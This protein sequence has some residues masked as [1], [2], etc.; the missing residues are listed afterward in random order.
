MS[1]ASVLQKLQLNWGHAGL[2]LNSVA[3]SQQ[4]LLLLRSLHLQSLRLPFLVELPFEQ[5]PNGKYEPR[6]VRGATQY[7]ETCGGEIEYAAYEMFCSTKTFSLR[8]FASAIDALQLAILMELYET[9]RVREPRETTSRLAL[10]LRE[11]VKLLIV[12]SRFDQRQFINAHAAERLL[13]E[14]PARIYCDLDIQSKDIYRGAVDSL[15][16]RYGC[17]AEQVA[18]RALAL[19]QSSVVAK[20]GYCHA[21]HIGFFLIDSGK[22]ELQRSL[23]GSGDGRADDKCEPETI[24]SVGGY[25]SIMM[26]VS[27]CV[28]VA[29]VFAFGISLRHFGTAIIVA[30]A[31]GIVGSE[32]GNRLLDFFLYMHSRPRLLPRVDFSRGIPNEHRTLVCIPSLLL[33]RSHVE[34]LVRA[35]ENIH[36]ITYDR[37]VSYALLT[38]FVDSEEPSVTDEE[39]NTLAHA[40]RLIEALNEKYS[41]GGKPFFFLLHRSREYS[42]TE[43]CWMGRDRKRGKISALNRL[44][45]FGRNEFDFVSADVKTLSGVRYVVTLDDDTE[46]LPG[47]IQKL[48]GLC[49]HP[50]NEPMLDTTGKFIRSGYCIFQPFP[51]IT[52]KSAA[53]LGFWKAILESRIDLRH[54]PFFVRDVH[55]DVMAECGFYGKGIYRVDCFVSVLKD[56]IPP[57]TV[58]SHDTIEAGFLRTGYT[59]DV[60]FAESCPS[61]LKQYYERAHRWARGDWQNLLMLLGCFG[62]K[63]TRLAADMS[64]YAK[65]LIFRFVRRSLAPISRTAILVTIVFG[66][67]TTERVRLVSLYF[68]LMVPDLY[69]VAELSLRLLWTGRFVRTLR[70]LLSKISGAHLREFLLSLM[71]PHYFLVMSDAII[72]AVVRSMSGEKLLDW[73]AASYLE[74]Q[75]AVFNF[76]DR[77][78]W[79]ALLGTSALIVWQYLDGCGFA[80]F[81][82]VYSW[83]GYILFYLFS[84]SKANRDRESKSTITRVET[85]G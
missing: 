77:C 57:E 21:D 3:C 12:A 58:L 20:E 72:R 80:R 43:R 19:C 66:G 46:L 53:R 34:C 30:L 67:Q 85:T 47:A 18:T 24:L 54:G 81:V 79:L 78:A 14:D 9:N 75:R 68:L 62:Q 35:L 2:G 45:A 8:E 82:I 73:K 60:I 32:T 63:A 23:R 26:A 71:A 52:E 56:R 13:R 28:W 25:I 50:L 22:N 37:N 74:K 84:T 83:L 40:K 65:Y 61:D 33:S 49:A 1:L 38:D 59:G 55:F 76:V 4:R 31:S 16:E 39:E 11:L 70:L 10:R 42:R 44:I 36:L 5:G 29:F 17:S 69:Y 7:L 48:V 64:A 51:C 6:I 41:R 15:A 27:F